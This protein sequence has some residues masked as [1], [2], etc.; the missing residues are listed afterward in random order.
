M[1]VGSLMTRVYGTSGR[2]GVGAGVLWVGTLTEVLVE[3]K[4]FIL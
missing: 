3:V 2:S 1:S 4:Y